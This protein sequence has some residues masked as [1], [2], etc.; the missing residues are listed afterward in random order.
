MLS[1]GHH[2]HAAYRRM[3]KVSWRPAHRRYAYAMEFSSA[4]YSGNPNERSTSSTGHSAVPMGWI[5]MISVTLCAASLLVQWCRRNFGS[6]LLFHFGQRRNVVRAFVIS[7]RIA[8]RILPS[9][10]GYYADLCHIL[11]T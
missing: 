7:D 1:S 10:W 6:Y 2:Y 9:S 3:C 4:W 11:L 8:P 5:M